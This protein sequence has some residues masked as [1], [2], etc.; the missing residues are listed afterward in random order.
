MLEMMIGWLDGKIKINKLMIE[1]EDNLSDFE[2]F[3]M[4]DNEMLAKIKEEL[5]KR[6]EAADDTKI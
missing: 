6:E 3:L 1:N 4:H 2:L 5:L